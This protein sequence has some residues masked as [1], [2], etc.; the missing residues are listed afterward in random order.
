MKTFETSVEHGEYRVIFEDIGEGYNGEYDSEDPPLLRFLVERFVPDKKE[1]LGGLWEQ[2]DDAS[3]CTNLNADNVTTEQ[4][5]KAAKLIMDLV[6]STIKAGESVK[7]LC[8][9]LSWIES[10]DI[11]AGTLARL[12]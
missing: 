4:A 6:M 7:K 1:T 9:K 8:D 3:Y 10:S 11:E 12:L 5:K 2:I